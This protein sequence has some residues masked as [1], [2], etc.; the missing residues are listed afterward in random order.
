MFQ[1]QS[2]T[3]QNVPEVIPVIKN[4]SYL[5]SSNNPGDYFKFRQKGGACL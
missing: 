1:G 4:F 2:L 3:L 5:F